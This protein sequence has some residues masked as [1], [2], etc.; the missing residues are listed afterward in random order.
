M[1]YC[2]QQDIQD[3][4]KDLLGDTIKE[5]IEAEMDGHLGYGSYDRSENANYQNRYKGYVYGELGI[6]CEGRLP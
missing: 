5:M 1:I 4:L 2:Q 3:V 6:M